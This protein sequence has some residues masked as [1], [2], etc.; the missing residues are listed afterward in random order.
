M[1]GYN[2]QAMTHPTTF[3]EFLPAFFGIFTQGSF[4]GADFLRGCMKSGLRY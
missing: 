4:R 1:P 2:Q 3:D